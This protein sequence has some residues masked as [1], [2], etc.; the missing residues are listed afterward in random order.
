[1]TLETEHFRITYPAELLELAQ[2]AGS[3]AERA[4]EALAQ[5]FAK[6]PK[7]TVDL[8]ITDH[9]DIS[10]GFAR[11]FPSNR[12][13]WE[14]LAR[15]GLGLRLLDLDSAGPSFEQDLMNLCDERTRLLTVSSVQYARG[16]RLD[17]DRLGSFFCR[18]SDAMS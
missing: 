1:M 14:S 17:L 2:R 3:R 4:W 16:M 7:K 12:I 10:N 13:V 15:R 9:A 8:I 5:D 18:E 11:A 6:P